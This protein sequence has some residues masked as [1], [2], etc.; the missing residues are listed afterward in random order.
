MLS[1]PPSRPA[2]CEENCTAR[3]DCHCGLSCD[4]RTGAHFLSY[5]K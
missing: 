4:K 3:E 1:F 2:C 5:K